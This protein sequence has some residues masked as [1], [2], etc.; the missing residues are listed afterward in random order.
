MVQNWTQKKKKWCK[1]G[2]KNASNLDANWDATL[3]VKWGAKNHSKL[4]AKTNAKVD[5]KMAQNRT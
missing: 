4:G 5:E 2:H 1:N 3:D